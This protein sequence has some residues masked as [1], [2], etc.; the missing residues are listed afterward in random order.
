V[1]KEGSKL[2]LMMEQGYR[3]E[4][5][6]HLATPWLSS[7]SSPARKSGSPMVQFSWAPPSY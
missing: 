2:G 7:C 6:L 4:P 3:R 1:C 5:S